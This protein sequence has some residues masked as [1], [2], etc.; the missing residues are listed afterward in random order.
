MLLAQLHELGVVADVDD[1]EGLVV[2]AELQRHFAGRSL[3]VLN[4]KLPTARRIEERCERLIENLRWAKA[5][6]C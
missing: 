2:G 4:V 6:R 1:T 3:Q 5:R